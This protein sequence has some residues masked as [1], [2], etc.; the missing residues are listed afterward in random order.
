MALKTR[1]EKLEQSLTPP[2]RYIP[3]EWHSGRESQVVAIDRVRAREALPDGAN[4]S[5]ILLDIDW[6]GACD[7]PGGPS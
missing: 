3:V 4:V 1:V 6:G 2:M 7:H 5:W